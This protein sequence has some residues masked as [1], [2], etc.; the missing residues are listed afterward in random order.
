[1]IKKQYFMDAERRYF[2]FEDET[3]KN[4]C[5]CIVVE[6]EPGAYRK[7]LKDLVESGVCRM[8]AAVPF[9]D[10]SIDLL[11][12]KEV[13]FENI[14]IEIPILSRCVVVLDMRNESSSSFD[15]E[16][17]KALA[18]YYFKKRISGS[19]RSFFATRY[20]SAR[21]RA[22]G[23]NGMYGFIDLEFKGGMSNVA[24]TG[25][26]LQRVQSAV[27]IGLEDACYMT[28]NSILC[29]NDTVIFNFQGWVVPFPAKK[30]TKLLVEI[31]KSGSKG[32][33]N[34]ELCR[35]IEST[36]YIPELAELPE[37]DLEELG[38]DGS[39]HVSGGR[40]V[41]ETISADDIRKMQDTVRKYEAQQDLRH[42]KAAELESRI[43][44]IEKI[45]PEL[46]EIHEQ[47]QQSGDIDLN[48]F[49]ERLAEQLRIEDPAVTEGQVA[50]HAD[51]FKR[52][53]EMLEQLCSLHEERDA[54]DTSVRDYRSK[55][56]TWQR[57]GRP[58][59]LII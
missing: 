36:A 41:K 7:L 39:M 1:M 53:C 32:I 26:D 42:K 57:P 10:V 9:S 40:K 16:Q 6:D 31:I 14:S 51:L 21:F 8:A 15:G 34:N 54:V 45:I 43:S 19:A 24:L 25:Q 52:G 55:I 28:G 5:C 13:K 38:P 49:A 4:N 37:I 48:V 29:Y 27:R 23:L 44:K 30:P 17:D 22:D 59:N 58:L 47:I 20:G 11:N 50:N 35:L 33:H 46:R 12:G 18:G 56:K 2:V 3:N